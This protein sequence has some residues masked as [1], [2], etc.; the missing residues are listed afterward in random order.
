[1]QIPKGFKTFATK[2]SK[3]KSKIAR[4]FK[5]LGY[6]LF[7]KQIILLVKI[8]YG[9]KQSPKEWQ[10][11]FKT[12]LNELSFK[13]LVLDSTVFYNPDNGI[14]IMIIVDNYLFIGPNINEINAVKRKIAKKYTIKDR[15]PATYFLGVQI[16]QNRMKEFLW[17]FQSYYIKEVLKRFEF[18][19]SRFILILL[20]PG[21]LKPNSNPINPV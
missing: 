3:E 15:G 2:I 21:L 20:Q 10:L 4:L 7:K 14:F 17:L 1:M 12:L 11:K 16:I 18:K 13:P 19:N 5:K 9:L 8:L 6:N